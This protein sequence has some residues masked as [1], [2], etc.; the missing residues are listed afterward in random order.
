[1]SGSDSAMCAGFEPLLSEV[2]H[3]PKGDHAAVRVTLT[4]RVAA[5]IVEPAQAEGGAIV[6]EPGYLSGLVEKRRTHGV[7]VILD[8]VKCGTA[9]TETLFACESDEAV[10]DILVSGKVPWWRRDATGR[11]RHTRGD[12]EQVPLQLSHVFVIRSR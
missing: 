5:V 8:E 9:K 3:V 7:A 2:T 12:A 10:P 4:D 6:P 11:D 1:M